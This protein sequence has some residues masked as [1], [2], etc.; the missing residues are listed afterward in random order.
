MEA[1]G[2]LRPYKEILN[3]ENSVGKAPVYSVHS[4]KLL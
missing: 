4:K 3:E 1:K 2:S